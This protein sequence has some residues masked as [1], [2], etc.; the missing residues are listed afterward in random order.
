MPLIFLMLLPLA[1]VPF[2]IERD[3]KW[4]RRFAWMITGIQTIWMALQ[5][6]P[7]YSANL[8]SLFPHLGDGFELLVKAVIHIY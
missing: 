7:G 8:V 6:W 5:A 3:N 1:L 2:L 4:F